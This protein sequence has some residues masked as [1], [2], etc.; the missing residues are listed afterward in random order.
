[1][2]FT[3]NRGAYDFAYCYVGRSLGT[4]SDFS[5]DFCLP[6]GRFSILQYFRRVEDLKDFTM[7]PWIVSAYSHGDCLYLTL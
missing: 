3:C 1:M 5:K 4:I 2:F 6:E 7:D